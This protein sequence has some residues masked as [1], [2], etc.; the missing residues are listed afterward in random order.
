M[1][2]VELVDKKLYKYKRRKQNQNS[3]HKEIQEENG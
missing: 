1:Q 2:R 3:C